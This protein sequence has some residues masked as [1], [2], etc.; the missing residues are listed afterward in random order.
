MGIGDDMLQYL[1]EEEKE[2]IYKLGIDISKNEYV[3]N[4]KF[5]DLQKSFV[6][7]GNEVL[8]EAWFIEKYIVGQE[9]LEEIYTP[10]AFGI[11]RNL[12]EDELE[13][14]AWFEALSTNILP[15]RSPKD[16]QR[17]FYR[18]E[19][20]D[21]NAKK[22]LIKRIEKTGFYISDFQKDQDMLRLLTLLYRF[23]SEFN[24]KWTPYY[25]NATIENVDD[26]FI[27]LE[28]KN[29][30]LTSFLKRNIAKNL[31]VDYVRRVRDVLIAIGKSWEWQI[32]KITVR[33]DFSWKGSYV[34]ELKRIKRELQRIVGYMVEMPR[35]EYKENIL[36]SFYLKLS[37]YEDIGLENDL[38]FINEKEIFSTPVHY[39]VDEFKRLAYAPINRDKMVEYLEEN[40]TELLPLVFEKDET[41]KY[42]SKRYDKAVEYFSDFIEMLDLNTQAVHQEVFPKLYP[43][44]FMQEILSLDKKYKIENKYYRH[45]TTELKSLYT[46]LRYGIYARRKSQIAI[47]KRVNN[48]LYHYSGRKEEAELTTEIEV[49]I[50]KILHRI[51]ETNCIEDMLHAHSFFMNTVDTV[52]LLDK[53][54]EGTQKSLLKSVR[55]KS[56]GYELKASS[57]DLK[58]FFLGTIH[59]S[60]IIMEVGK[61]IGK[62]DLKV[63]S[64]KASPLEDM[65]LELVGN[66]IGK[67]DRYILRY[68][69]DV[70]EKT[71]FIVF[72][73]EWPKNQEEHEMN[74]RCGI[75]EKS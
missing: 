43:I 52:F 67:T 35:A 20:G 31:S 54:I 26:S 13:D 41:S 57:D 74:R 53:Q 39:R 8:S 34:D 70:A 37:Q 64:G 51:Y 22:G 56:S 38:I 3:E 1:I 10:Y 73:Y 45:Q 71:I 30:E 2:K 24:V 63:E 62:R 44:V 50:D 66:Y 6:V 25:S 15:T 14:S 69:I 21:D 9:R 16:I 65:E 28:T 18:D 48:R 23:E 17:Y 47:I 7:C 33:L 60:P 27:G 72:F 59:N 32:Q 11:E 68:F 49:Y 29:G 40:K 12:N 4:E 58:R 36:E 5:K 55:R 19:K 46:E 61:K 42:E 75:R